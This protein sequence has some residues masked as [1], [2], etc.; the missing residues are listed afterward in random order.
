M[1][2]YYAKGN[3]YN[4]GININNII[5]RNRKEFGVI[6]MV[7]LLYNEVQ[8]YQQLKKFIKS[9]KKDLLKYKNIDDN[10]LEKEHFLNNLV[11]KFNNGLIEKMHTFKHSAYSREEEIRIL[12][13]LPENHH[14][15][16]NF[17]ISKNGVVVEFIK[18][19]LDIEK[20]LRSI[21]IHPLG[22]S[23]H[24]TGIKRFLA[25]MS[26]NK[27]LKIQNSLIPFRNV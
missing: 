12:I 5:E 16:V 9:F 6:F 8:Q 27:R 4:L 26:T 21:T 17:R 25:T 11:M 19:N 10:T 24:E 15:D 13:A 22:S 20:D 1:W 18:L 14:K 23:L 3:G 2:N 7:E